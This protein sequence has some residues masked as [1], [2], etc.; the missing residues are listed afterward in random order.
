MN[1]VLRR[2]DRLIILKEK[3]K[4]FLQQKALNLEGKFHFNYHPHQL[5]KMNKKKK[6]NQKRK[7][8]L[9]VNLLKIISNLKMNQ[10][11]NHKKLKI[12][13][14]YLLRIINKN[15]INKKKI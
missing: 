6:K 11:Q 3:Y 13:K 14:V 1:S 2:K 9:R 4:I 15:I 12:N 10:A 5:I 7:L 8:K